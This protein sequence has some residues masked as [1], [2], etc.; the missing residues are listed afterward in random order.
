LKNQLK[1]NLLGEAFMGYIE[2][3]YSLELMKEA[4]QR[5]LNDKD[6]TE[7]SD[8]DRKSLNTYIEELHEE[9]KAIREII[10]EK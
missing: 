5:M 2:F 3:L 1:S 10:R 7:L 9:I 8:D 6:S 4:K